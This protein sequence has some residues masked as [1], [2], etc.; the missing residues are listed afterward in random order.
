MLNNQREWMLSTL[1]YARS[2]C[3]LSVAHFKNA[4]FYKAMGCVGDTAILLDQ[5]I[6]LMETEEVED[7]D[8]D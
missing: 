6:E 1:K 7:E 5:M 8:G 4:K 3:K 2:K